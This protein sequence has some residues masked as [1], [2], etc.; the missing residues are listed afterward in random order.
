MP[1]T[2]VLTSQPNGRG[3][4]SLELETNLRRALAREEFVLQFQA[5][6][7]LESGQIDGFEA[8]IRWQRPGQ[9]LVAP[10]EFIP[11]LEQTGLIVNVGEWVLRA[12]CRQIH[13]WR[14]EGVTPLP[15]AINLS[16]T[17]FQ[18]QDMAGAV[19]RAL[20]EFEV[21]P[22]LLEIEIT[23]GTAMGHGEDIVPALRDL[24]A[25]GV[26]IAIDDFGTGYSSLSYL[27]RFPADSI[28]IDRSFIDQVADSPDDAAI[29]KAI[30]TMA[31]CLQLRVVAVGVETAAQL[32]FLVA[33]DCDQVQGY[34]FSRPVAA[35]ECTA[36]LKGQHRLKPSRRSGDAQRMA[37]LVDQEGWWKGSD[38]EL[39]ALF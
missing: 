38:K 1:G 16:A 4:E 6:V 2:S 18:R 26:R 37:R 5:K 7:S 24:K 39:V 29:A 25:L 20:A 13:A 34:Y 11:L 23:E 31:H 12:A 22:R 32:A 30:I 27:K 36:M 9:E 21:D 35:A 28:K 14:E 17:Q 10:D 15:I 33:N 19:R 3:R 8:L